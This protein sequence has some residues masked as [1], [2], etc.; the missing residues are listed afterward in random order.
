MFFLLLAF[1]AI[2]WRT[3]HWLM[4]IVTIVVTLSLS[5]GTHLFHEGI[6]NT[7]QV[8]IGI[9][10]IGYVRTKSSKVQMLLSLTILFLLTVLTTS[11][12]MYQMLGVMTGLIISDKNVQPDL[13][14]SKLMIGFASLCLLYVPIHFW[15]PEGLPTFTG[16]ALLGSWVSLRSMHKKRLSRMYLVG[17]ILLITASFGS[18]KMDDNVPAYASDGLHKGGFPIHHQ[19][20]DGKKFAVIAHRGN[21]S[22]YPEETLPALKS[23][24]DM[25]VDFLDVDV[26]VTKDHQL[27]ALHDDTVD[28]TTNGT[29]KASEM[30][31]SELKQLDAGYEMT[32]DDGQ[33][34]PF[35][36]QGIQLQTLRELLEAFP[37]APFTIEI[38]DDSSFAGNLV[39][40][41][42]QEHQAS[43]RVIVGS[44]HDAPTKTFRRAM[45][46]VATTLTTSEMKKM[47]LMHQ[48][49]LGAYD[50]PPARYAQVP[51]EMDGIRVLT[52]S[53][54]KYAHQRGVTL[55][56]WTIN[57]E[58]E[59]K[60]IMQM[61]VDGMYTDHPARLLDV[62]VQRKK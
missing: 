10:F 45:P 55:F 50:Q 6:V 52:P 32:T 20:S 46:N 29:G 56:V 16:F 51:E 43:H 33:S 19:T 59:M 21:S 61:G 48:I 18:V 54:I 49:G 37:N 26:H 11:N 58:D 25:Q 53:F 60:R 30:T 22:S 13:P 41:V 2:Y 23:A 15:V 39:A 8:V 57:E 9:L 5:F 34:Y 28:R 7:M 62:V 44:F 4:G 36:G 24:K 1:A 47:M 27:I 17:V 42:I 31:V 35:R 3:T 40:E 12:T 14:R 38:K